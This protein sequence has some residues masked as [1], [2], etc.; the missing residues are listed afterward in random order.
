MIFYEIIS[1]VVRASCKTNHRGSTDKRAALIDGLVK[2]V[3]NTFRGYYVSSFLKCPNPTPSHY[4]NDTTCSSYKLLKFL[5]LHFFE[6][7][8]SAVLL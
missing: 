3:E 8:M 1:R 5:K 4:A 7:L 2:L 6:L